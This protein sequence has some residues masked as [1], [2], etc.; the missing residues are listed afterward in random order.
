M[1]KTVNQE[2]SSRLPDVAGHPHDEPQ[3]A[4]DWVGMSE[5]AS[6]VS[7][8]DIGTNHQVDTMVELYINLADAHTKGIHMSRLYRSLRQFA[9]EN[10]LAPKSLSAFL[11]HLQATHPDTSNQASATF[12]FDL[13]LSRPSL[14]SHNEGFN[15][16]PIKLIGRLIENEVHI[17]IEFVVHYSSTCPASAALSRSLIQAQFDADFEEHGTIDAQDVKAWLG[18][19]RGIV[20]TPHGQRSA[21]TVKVHL[22]GDESAFPLTRMID[23]VEDALGTP[24]Q[25]AVKR[26]DEQEF[27]YRNGQN[28]MF[29]EDAA[30]YIKTALQEQEEIKDFYVRVEHFESLHA[31]NAVAAVTKGIERGY[32]A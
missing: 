23:L 21:A 20:A 18:S 31:H 14:I 30:R 8:A 4:L 19:Q 5:I 22:I 27:A 6:K 13:L 16:Y 29:C 15:R 24:V 10:T 17:E 1:H 11:V 12:N 2:I 26:E 25:T 9:T 7:I 32:R 3:G 28:P